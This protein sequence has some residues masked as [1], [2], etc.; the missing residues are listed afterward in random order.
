MVVRFSFR[1]LQNSSSVLSTGTPSWFATPQLIAWT[2]YES[3][4]VHVIQAWN[5]QVWM[6]SQMHQYTYLPEPETGSAHYAAVNNNIL[7]T[8]T[9]TNQELRGNLRLYLNEIYWWTRSREPPILS[10]A[11]LPVK[12]PSFTLRPYSEWE[13]LIHR[14]QRNVLTNRKR[15][16]GEV[17]NR[18]ILPNPSL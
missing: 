12:L 18:F 1:C 14:D 9:K 11:I 8:S 5:I 10:H 3:I 4:R 7:R 17:Q 16:W 15:D 6:Y 13:I 2:T